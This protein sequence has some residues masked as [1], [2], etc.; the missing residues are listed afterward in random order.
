MV[1][2]LIYNHGIEFSTGTAWPR[3]CPSDGG[4]FC[5]RNYMFCHTLDLDT[6]LV[7]GHR[8]AVFYAANERS[9]GFWCFV[10]DFSP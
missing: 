7:F 3:A 4:L 5:H 9:V 6:G 2:G 8:I 10:G 1:T